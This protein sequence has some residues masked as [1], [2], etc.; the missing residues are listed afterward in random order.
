M[1]ASQMS[2]TVDFS[3]F[4]Q[5]ARKYLDDLR[6]N[7]FNLNLQGLGGGTFHSQ[8]QGVLGGFRQ[9]TPEYEVLLA[10]YL[11]QV[12]KHLEENGWLGKEYIYWFD[13]PHS[14]HY[15]FVRKGMTNIRKAAPRLTRFIT[16]HRPGPDIM[17][18]SEISC[19][20][21]HRV[22]PKVVADLRKQG[23]EFWSYLCT[24]PK[25][26]W[27]TLFIDHPAIN[28]RMWLWIS[29]QYQLEGILVWS[30]NYWTSNTT[31]PQDSRQN[32]WEDPMAYRM[33]YG[34]PFGQVNYWGNGDG[35]FLY[36]PNRNVNHDTT[37]YLTGPVNSIRWEILREGIEDYEYFWLLQEAVKKASPDQSELV[38]SARQLLD[39]PESIFSD[40]QTYTK[41]PKVLLEYRGRVAETLEA[42]LN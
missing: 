18:V 41:D 26:P 30:S 32:P 35:R 39:I 36:P 15:P 33:G 34:T 8:H 24:G 29:F 27:V 5:G 23:R 37:K 25:A 31:F 42:L 3:E 12:E 21:F 20:I 1:E 28:L 19:T 17:D 4:D 9:D 2:V 7:S 11:G 6:F 13:E 10:S 16:E 22:E 14:R 38:K 40:G